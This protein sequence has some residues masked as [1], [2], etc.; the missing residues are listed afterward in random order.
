MTIDVL[1]EIPA[2]SSVKYEFDEDNKR[3]YVDRFAATPMAYP[4]NYGMVD[5]TKAP[6]GDPLDAFVLTIKA[7][8]PGAWIR[9]KVIGMI[10]MK[11]EK[12]SDNKLL[13]V[14]ET[15][16]M[17]QSTGSWQN[18]SDIPQDRLDKIKHFL[19][20]Y[21]DL[22]PGKWVKV[23]RFADKIEAEQILEESRVK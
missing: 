11:D 2:N 3:L 20:H 7:I 12:G 21:K 19:E 14:P 23:E 18:L 6:D 15:P 9:S 5:Q 10:V 13:C 1:I 4:E 22:E 16:G 17:D 8:V